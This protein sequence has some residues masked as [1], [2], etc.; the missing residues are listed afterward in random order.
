MN[1]SLFL[2]LES[3][4]NKDLA[5]F[6]LRCNWILA[7]RTDRHWDS[8]RLRALP[9]HRSKVE[10]RVI[11]YFNKLHVDTCL[12]FS[13][14]RWPTLQCPVVYKLLKL[15][16]KS[17]H[18]DLSFSS[19]THLGLTGLHRSPAEPNR[20]EILLHRLPWTQSEVAQ[21]IASMSHQHCRYLMLVPRIIE[22]AVTSHWTSNHWREPKGFR[23]L[24]KARTFK[25]E[26]GKTG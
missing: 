26:K 13:G 3:G 6:G 21:N 19:W 25:S 8:K 20:T 17:L 18:S 15:D 1:P 11:F 12:K 16:F 24:E 2:H 23:S 14:E 7:G 9:Y 10:F 5:S 4:Y 22:Q